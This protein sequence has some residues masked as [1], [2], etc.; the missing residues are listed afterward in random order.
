[1][2]EAAT[3]GVEAD[4]ALVRR[5][6]AG[7]REAFAELYRRYARVVHGLLLARVPYAEVDDQAQEVFI[8]ALRKLANLRDPQAFGGWLCAIARNRA[9]DFHR[10]AD[11][12]VELNENATAAGGSSENAEAAEALRAVR[13]LPDAYRETLMLRLVEGLTGAEIAAR[14]GLT[15]GSVR[16][17]LHRGMELLRKALK[18]ELPS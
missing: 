5:A 16:V 10:S 7:D 8:S 17:N 11:E 3:S 6:Q 13:S 14:T 12:A 18:K 15:H 9:A 2:N 4:G 1:M